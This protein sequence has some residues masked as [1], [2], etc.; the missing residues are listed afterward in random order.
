MGSGVVITEYLGT[1][2]HVKIP[3]HVQGRPVTGIADLAFARRGLLSVTIPDGVVS[4]G[5]WA[6]SD[7]RLAEVVLGESLTFIGYAAFFNNDIAR[8]GWPS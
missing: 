7:N 5:D 4:I 6:F 2:V 1:D 8:K 3:A